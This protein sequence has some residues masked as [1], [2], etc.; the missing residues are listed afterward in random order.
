[1]LASDFSHIEA[2]VK[3]AE[4]SGADWL[5]MDVMDGHFVDNISFGP[6][7]VAAVKKCTHLPLDVHLMISHPDHYFSRFVAHARN[8]TVHV[9][10][11][12]DVASTLFN[13]R[14]HGCTVGLSFNPATPFE[15]VIPFLNQI[16]LLLVM[17]VVPGFGGQSFMPETLSKVEAAA[18]F[19]SQHGLSYRI[20]VDGGINTQ[21]APQ[22]V[23]RGADTL[24]VGT[25]AFGANDMGAAI[26]SAREACAIST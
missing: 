4:N 18:E 10:A 24:V 15:R 5:H 11:K 25:F 21:T 8:V 17:T 9:E 20:E 2:E 13:I 12:H 16:D 22:T 26:R 1:M 19:R 6:A 14:K 7:F 23:E 3:R